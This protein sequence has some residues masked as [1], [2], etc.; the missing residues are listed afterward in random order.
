MTEWDSIGED[1]L[2]CLKG[3]LHLR[4]P[5]ERKRIGGSISERVEDMG[6]ARREMAVKLS[7]P[8]KR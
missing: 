1:E 8:K 5:G 2:C 3:N 6:N 4:G 7:M